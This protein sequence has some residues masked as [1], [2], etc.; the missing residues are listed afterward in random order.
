MIVAMTDY[1]TT[2]AIFMICVAVVLC[3]AMVCATVLIIKGKWPSISVLPDL[4]EH[5]DEDE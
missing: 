3:V 2:D 1:Q 4:P 5:E